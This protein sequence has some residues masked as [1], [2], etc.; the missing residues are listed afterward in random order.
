MKPVSVA[1]LAK[2]VGGTVHGDGAKIICG[3]ADLHLAAPDQ[4]CFLSDVSYADRARTTN[5]GA[6]LVAQPTETKAAQVVVAD[7]RLAFV[8]VVGYFHPRPKATEQNVHPRAFVADGVELEAPVEIGPNAV[9]ETG[10]RMGRGS[11][12]MSGSVVQKGARIG[13]DC[14]LYPIV[15]IC[16]GVVLGDR[17]TI[18]AG[19]VIGGSGFGYAREDDKWIA[20]PQ[21]GTVVLDD[22]VEI[23]C[24]CAI[25]RAAIGT[26]RIGS[27]TKID[28]LVHFGHNVTV[29]SDTVIAAGSFFSG[30]VQIGSRVMIGGH[31]CSAGHLK[32]AD[33]AR[34]GGNSGLLHD[35][36]EAKDYMGWPLMEKSRWI[37]TMRAVDGLLE[38][39]QEVRRLAQLVD[40]VP[41]EGKDDTDG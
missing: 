41:Q 37:R 10:V 6:L 31:T 27:G 25:D 17:V 35:V 9:V 11:V 40:G 4:I 5:A 21:I 13:R 15:T 7:P 8:K 1:N 12:L 30:S 33:G 36:P 14:V 19:T 29:G 2:L 24:N 38:L 3:V 34:I 16:A 22:D 28:N 18:Q 23:G 20:F 39:R 32:I 26:T